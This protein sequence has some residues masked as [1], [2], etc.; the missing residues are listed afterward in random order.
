MTVYEYK[1][2][3]NPK[4]YYPILTQL[5]KNWKYIDSNSLNDIQVVKSCLCV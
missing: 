4:D 1:I 3:L 5:L 2:L